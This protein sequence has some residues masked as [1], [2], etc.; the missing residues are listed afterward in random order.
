MA[1]VGFEL[2]RLLQNNTSLTGR[3]QAY[4]FAALIGSGPWLLSIAAILGIALHS[5]RQN[6]SADV[7]GQFQVS[8]TCLMAFSLILTGPLQ[9][10]FTRFVA[11]RLFEQQPRQIM[12]N[13]FGALSLA[14]LTAGLVGSAAL[15]L[16]FDGSLLYR[17]CMLTGFVTLC[18]I[19]IVMVFASAINAYR[20]I[21]LVFLLGYSITFGASLSLR[22]FGLEGLLLGF[23]V[24]QACLFFAL[25]A[26]VVRQYPGERMVS[27]DFLRPGKIYLSLVFTGLFYNAGIWVDKFIFWADPLTG[28]AIVGPLRA[29]PAYDLPIFLSYLSL[30]PGMAVFLVR[31][32][33]DFAEKCE[34]FYRTILRGGTLAQVSQARQELVDAVRSGLLVMLKVQGATSCLLLLTGQELLAWLGISGVS[35]SLLNIDLVAVVIQLLLLGMLTV[36]FYLDQRMAALSLCLLFFSSNAVFSWISLAL[37]PALHGYGFFFSVLLTASAGLVILL[38]KLD[39]LEYETF[40]L[41]PVIF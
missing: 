25:L 39:Q 9:L 15:A 38:K 21:L 28:M 35:V 5:T 29:S 6:F 18:G 31:V 1:G 23:V 20:Q 10:T 36:L 41:Q 33:T 3:G 11:D 8:V 4:A 37:G 13:L 34:N 30:I 14:L 19:W 22:D 24:G 2:R 26:L 32:E 40:M 12:A 27:F 7:V 16:W 17:Q